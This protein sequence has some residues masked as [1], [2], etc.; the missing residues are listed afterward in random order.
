M[1]GMEVGLL[2][3]LS[4]EML[5]LDFVSFHISSFFLRSS[6]KGIPKHDAVVVGKDEI[7]VQS[8]RTGG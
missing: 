5:E 4:E 3:G 8:G 6:Q 2:F 1:A 7:H